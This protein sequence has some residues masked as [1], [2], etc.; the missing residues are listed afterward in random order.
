MKHLLIIL[1]AA[2][3]CYAQSYPTAKPRPKKSPSP[4]VY[5]P[6]GTVYTDQNG[7]DQRVTGPGQTQNVTGAARDP[8]TGQRIYTPQRVG[9]KS[10]IN[11]GGIGSGYPNP[12]RSI[13]PSNSGSGSP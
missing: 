6:K 4:A 1:L 11:A 7:Q 12:Q 9:K 2:G 8:S 5:L 3:I 13:N 10:R